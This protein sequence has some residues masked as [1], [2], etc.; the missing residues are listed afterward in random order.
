MASKITFWFLKGSE[1][2]EKVIEEKLDNIESKLNERL[3]EIQ[4]EINELK[5]L[6]G[7]K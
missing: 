4:S 1:K 3:D 6:I 5:E 2:E 7:K